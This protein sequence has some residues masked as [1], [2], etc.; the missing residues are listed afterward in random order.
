MIQ[1]YNIVFCLTE[2][3]VILLTLILVQLV[4]VEYTS[5]RLIIITFLFAFKFNCYLSVENQKNG[6]TLTPWIESN[7][8]TSLV[9]AIILIYT[10]G[11]GGGG[12]GDAWC[13]K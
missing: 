3:P 8:I 7:Q 13:V 1:N 4:E 5:S 2:Y 12:S 6:A 11:G 9:V 10:C